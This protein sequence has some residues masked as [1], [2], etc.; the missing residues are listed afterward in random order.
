IVNKTDKLEAAVLNTQ[1]D[2]IAVT[3]TWL[4]DSILDCEITPPNYTILR[5]DRG[6]RGGG[7]AIL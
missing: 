2:I 3:E 1:P 6:S 5:K 4:S 7:A